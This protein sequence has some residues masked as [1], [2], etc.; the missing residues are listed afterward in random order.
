MPK[1]DILQF[2]QEKRLQRMFN[3]HDMCV[4]RKEKVYF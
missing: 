1:R 4:K 2:T 3:V